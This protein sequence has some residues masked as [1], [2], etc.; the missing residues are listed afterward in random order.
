MI[1]PCLSNS[2]QTLHLKVLKNYSFSAQVPEK[3]SVG[4]LE[5]HYHYRLVKILQSPYLGMCTFERTDF[6]S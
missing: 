4:H 2:A 3:V 6:K 5:S 1:L